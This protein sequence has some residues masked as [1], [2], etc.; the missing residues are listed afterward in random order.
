MSLQKHFALCMTAQLFTFLLHH[1]RGKGYITHEDLKEMLGSDYDK[2][3]V[4]KMIEEGDF[5]K[6]NQ[7]DYEELLQYMFSDPAHG[8][9]LVGHVTPETI[10]RASSVLEQDS[11]H[12]CD[13][14]L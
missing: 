9:K 13:E 5:K 4:D 8:D 12:D 6:N 2:E 10:Q 7:I 14:R 1:C 11:T 3:T